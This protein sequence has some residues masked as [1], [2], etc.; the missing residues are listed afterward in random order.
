[1]SRIITTDGN[2]NRIREIMIISKIDIKCLFETTKEL[3]G[4]VRFSILFANNQNLI[5]F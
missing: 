5:E 1:M 2:R 3:I 4:I